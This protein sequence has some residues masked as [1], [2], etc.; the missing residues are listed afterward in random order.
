[1]DSH[2]PLIASLQDQR[3]AVLKK[4]DGLSD[5]QARVVLVPSGWSLLDMA[6][7]LRTGEEYWIRAIIQGAVVS[8]DPDD[9]TGSWAWDTPAGLTLA[10]AT[11]RYR[12][13][14]D[15]T[16]AFLASLSSLD[17]PP[18]RL[19]YW[20][21]THHWARSIRTVVVHLIEETAR[22]AGHVDIVREQLDGR[23]QTLAQ[24]LVDRERSRGSRPD[25]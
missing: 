25:R 21:I 10:K 6:N 15:H 3:T 13:E 2:D 11:D 9:P 12:H 19:P 8:F 5:D 7:H 14:G 22:H 20:S 16:D 1:M 24:E 17:H 4:L 23:S 18:A